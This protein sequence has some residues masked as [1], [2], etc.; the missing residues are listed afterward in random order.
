MDKQNKKIAEQTK[1]PIKSSLSQAD[2]DKT[3][4]LAEKLGS[5]LGSPD[6]GEGAEGETEAEKQE[7]IDR[8]EQRLKQGTMK[9]EIK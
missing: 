1:K 2:R 3:D 5:M 4:N 6:F 9:F 7:Q 8:M